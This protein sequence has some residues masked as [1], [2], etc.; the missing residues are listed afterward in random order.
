V[1]PLADLKENKP[2]PLL[3]SVDDTAELQKARDRFQ[4]RTDL[5]TLPLDQPTVTLLDRI[6]GPAKSTQEVFETLDRQYRG[7]NKPEIWFLPLS[8]PIAAH[9]D[10]LLGPLPA[11][12]RE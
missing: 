9:L 10:E 5:A 6:L 8:Q 11:K 7:Q 4:A 3:P 12:E 1:T 2:L